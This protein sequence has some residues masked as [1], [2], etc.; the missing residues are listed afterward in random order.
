[1]NNDNATPRPWHVDNTGKGEAAIASEKGRIIATIHD[2]Y[3]ASGHLVKC[4]EHNAALIIRAVNSHDEMKRVL[5]DA[6]HWTEY[7]REYLPQDDNMRRDRATTIAAE[8]C[9]V[10]AKTEARI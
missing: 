9:V 3:D 5:T 4:G 6:L 7:A 1:M 8:I 10:L 2:R